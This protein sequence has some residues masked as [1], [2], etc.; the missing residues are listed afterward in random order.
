MDQVSLHAKE[1]YQMWKNDQP[2]VEPMW[3][4]HQLILIHLLN[5][6]TKGAVF[7]FGMGNGSTEL[8]HTI[9]REQERPLTSIESV[10][11]WMNKFKIYETPGHRIEL[12]D[13]IRLMRGNYDFMASHYSIIFVDAAPVGVRQKFIEQMKGKADY[14][15]V[16]DTEFVATGKGPAQYNYD[17]TG[18]KHVIHYTESHPTSTILSDLDE[19]DERIRL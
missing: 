3:E 12:F 13:P 11:V 1:R 4:S 6:I 14:F 8:M 9:C 15:L 7:E 19:I 16:H 2:Q 18:F 17:F 5:T 10:E